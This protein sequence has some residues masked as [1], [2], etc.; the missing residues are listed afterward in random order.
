[1]YKILLNDLN[2]K[3]KANTNL[4]ILFDFCQC[5]TQCQNSKEEMTEFYEKFL[6]FFLVNLPKKSGMTKWYLKNLAKPPDILH[7]PVYIL[8]TTRPLNCEQYVNSAL[9]ISIF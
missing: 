5:N 8:Y 6:T 9:I 2:K 1:M 7:S 4:P 3:L